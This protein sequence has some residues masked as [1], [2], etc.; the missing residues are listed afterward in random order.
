VRVARRRGGV[1]GVLVILVG[2]LTPVTGSLASS[3]ADAGPT[4]RAVMCLGMAAT[5]VGTVGADTINGTAGDDVLVGLGGNDII[6]GYGG[7]D[8]ICGG[9]GNDT[10]SG[11]PGND[12]V[13][14]NAG[15]DTISGGRGADVLKGGTGA[16]KIKGNAGR[17]KLFGEAGNDNL[18]GGLSIDRV[19]GGLGT[20]TCYGETKATC[21]L[22]APP[23]DLDFSSGNVHLAVSTSVDAISVI[24]VG[25]SGVIADLDVGILITH[26]YVGDLWVTLT[27]VDT[28]TVVT[29][30]DHPGSAV[31]PPDGSTTGD[32]GC[33]YNDIDATLNDEVSALVEDQCRST[34]PAISGS[35]RPNNPLRAF[36]GE[37]LSGTWRLTVYDEATG[38]SGFLESWSLHFHT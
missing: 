32:F 37:N 25:G 38:D 13:Q 7:N 24:Q 11:G 26:T 3:A 10:I 19:T 30:I 33:Q 20:D 5:R 34:S 2:A 16:D 9:P 36:D 8:R 12:Q 14:G 17:D 6:N 18:N 21:E 1:I 31:Y 22:P 4:G 35:V 28:R 29:I 15:D 23:A 27:H